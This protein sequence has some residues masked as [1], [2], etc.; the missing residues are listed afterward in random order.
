MIWTLA[1][2]VLVNV[3]VSII[4]AYRMGELHRSFTDDINAPSAKFETSEAERK[5]VVSLE[6]DVKA[7]KAYFS[8]A[9]GNVRNIRS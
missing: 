5:K 6:D 1:A 4:L 3:L 8:R 7:I 9:N 2:L